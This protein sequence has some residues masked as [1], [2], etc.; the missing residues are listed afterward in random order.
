MSSNYT[1]LKTLFQM[2][3]DGAGALVGREPSADRRIFRALRSLQLEI[4]A[5]DRP[6]EL[7]DAFLN[8]LTEKKWPVRAP[9]GNPL[10]EE[11]VQQTMDTF[12]LVWA[13]HKSGYKFLP[14]FAVRDGLNGEEV[15]KE[16]VSHMRSHV[17]ELEEVAQRLVS[18]QRKPSP[19][20]AS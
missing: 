18:E 16:L 12:P 4:K 8:A 6:V 17:S 5:S 9:G 19:P 15:R 7:H 3:A 14:E 20:R 13:L 11:K 2:A 10:T 1:T